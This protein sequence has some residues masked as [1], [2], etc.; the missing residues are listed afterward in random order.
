[1]KRSISW[2][3]TRRHER[4]V[5]TRYLMRF[6]STRRTTKY[7]IHVVRRWL[8]CELSR[9]RFACSTMVKVYQYKSTRSTTCE[10]RKWSLAIFS[11]RPTTMMSKQKW[12][13][14]VMGLALS[15]QM[16]FHADLRSRRCT[17]SH[18]KNFTWNE[19]ITW[20]SMSSPLLR[21]VMGQITHRWHSTP[22]LPVFT[23]PSFQKTWCCWWSDVFMTL[24]GARISQCGVTLMEKKLQLARSSSTLTCT[25]QWVSNVTRQVTP[26]SIR[27]GS[28]VCGCLTWAFSRSAL[29]TQS[30]PVV[31]VHTSS[32]F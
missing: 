27:A 19:P 3:S 26:R 31:G 7:V 29:S 22:T 24:P 9:R 21:R 2:S 30:T 14:D 13:E 20:R 15:W 8:R 10:Y 28:C 11:R 23:W 17:V 32:T 12:Q 1:M 16:C 18:V 5:C 6:W 25:R 4:Q